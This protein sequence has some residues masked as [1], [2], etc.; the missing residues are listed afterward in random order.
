MSEIVNR[1]ASSPIVT[2]RLEDLYPA[3]ERVLLDIKEQLFMGMIL[4]EKDFRAW[5]AEQDWSQYRGK[6]VAITCSADAIVPLWAYMLLAAQLQPYAE[7][8]VFGSLQDLEK[9]LLNRRLDEVDFSQFEGRPVVIKGCSDA[10][11]PTAVYVELT[12]RMMPYAKKISFGEPCSTV[13]IWK[14]D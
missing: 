14:K 7:T 11:I 2:F 4:R 5:I 1:V 6:F 3:G 9:T 13:P 12:R 8:V 10:P